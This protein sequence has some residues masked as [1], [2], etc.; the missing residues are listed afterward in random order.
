MGVFGRK[1]CELAAVN[2]ALI[3]CGKRKRSVP[4]SAG[5]LY[6]G[7]L[8]QKSVAYARKLGAERFFVLSARHGLVPFDREIEPYELT[9]NR[10]K[11]PERQAW[12]E[13]VI[14]EL[15]AQ[16]DCKNDHFILLA[17]DRYR[18]GLVEAL[19]NVTVPMAGLSLGRQLAFLKRA[20]Q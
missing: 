1:T 20:L 17:S 2:V 15:R 12:R 9:L 7:A 13:R 16:T 11:K 14:A 10:M 5:D 3:Q 4:C 8:F 18:D 6:I 19:R